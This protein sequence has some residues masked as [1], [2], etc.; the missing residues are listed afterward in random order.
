MTYLNVSIRRAVMVLIGAATTAAPPRCSISPGK[1]DLALLVF[2]ET[3]R[4]GPLS[5]N[6]NHRFALGEVASAESENRHSTTPEKIVRHAT[7]RIVE[8]RDFRETA[9]IL[10][11]G[12]VTSTR[13]IAIQ[14]LIL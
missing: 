10:L 5:F 4:T 13:T 8:K 9:I 7:T 3:I 2:L 11:A 1:E 6:E 12:S 14:D